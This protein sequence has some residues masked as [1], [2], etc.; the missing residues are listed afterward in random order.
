[1]W[2]VYAKSALCRVAMAFQNR[3]GDMNANGKEWHGPAQITWQKLKPNGEPSITPDP[4]QKR[5][6]L[7][8]RYQK[9]RSYRDLRDLQNATTEILAK[10]RCSD[11]R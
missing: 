4:L 6:S 8:D 5:L 1:M 7:I 2:L 11:A 3:A 10:G 9:S